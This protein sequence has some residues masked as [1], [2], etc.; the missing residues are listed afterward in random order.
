MAKKLTKQAFKNHSEKINNYAVPVDYMRRQ[1]F[2]PNSRISKVDPS[3]RVFFNDGKLKMEISKTQLH[4]RHRDLF[5]TLLMSEKEDISQSGSFSVKTSLYDLARKINYK[6]PRGSTHLVKELLE[7]MSSALIH[8]TKDGVDLGHH[9]LIGPVQYNKTDEGNVRVKFTEEFAEYNIRSVAMAF[10]LEMS[11]K[12]IDIPIKFAK[13]K[14]VCSYIASIGA[15]SG[16]GMDKIFDFLSIS[17][18]VGKSR[19]KKEVRDNINIY[20]DMGIYLVDDIFI[21]KSKEDEEKAKVMHALGK[22]KEIFIKTKSKIDLT[23]KSTPFIGKIL[24]LQDPNFVN[25]IIVKMIE[26]EYDIFD[27]HLANDTKK[28]VIRGVTIKALE[29]RIV[30]K[31]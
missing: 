24:D 15:K 30:D 7:D 18:A 20:E 10:P 1:M 5:A 26:T 17:D 8:V 25:P 29:A 28:G 22:D 11:N 3:R 21:I 31:S 16:I 9:Q 23:K 13:T 2:L 12:I 27:I 19:Y 6:N 4:Q 14:A